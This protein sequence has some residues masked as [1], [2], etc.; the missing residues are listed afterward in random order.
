MFFTVPIAADRA[1]NAE[2]AETAW[3]PRKFS[4]RVSYHIIFL[5]WGYCSP[6]GPKIGRMIS[7]KITF[8]VATPFLASRFDKWR[9]WIAMARLDRDLAS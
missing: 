3:L 7:K 4:A 9:G 8:A 2:L 6:A 1:A 5:S